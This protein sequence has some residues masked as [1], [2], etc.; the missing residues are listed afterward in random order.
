MRLKTFLLLGIL[1]LLLRFT[2]RAQ[3]LDPALARV[4]EPFS[5]FSKPTDVLGV[6]DGR[7]GTLVSPE[8]FLYTGYGELI[9]FAGNPPR[10]IEQRVKTL[11]RGYLPV[12]QY[13]FADR[14]EE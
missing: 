7:W 3:M 6:M 1:F 14:S 5:Y 8:G 2:S 12:I 9:F 4:G 10:P 13:T 11:L